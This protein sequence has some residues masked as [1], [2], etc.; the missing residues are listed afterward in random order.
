MSKKYFYTLF[1]SLCI[2]FFSSQDG[3]AQNQNPTVKT[4]ENIEGLYIYPNPIS[5][6]RVYIDTKLNGSKDIALYN[7]LGKKILS[8][9]L[10]G[11]ELILPYNIGSGVYIISIKEKDATATRKIV[12]K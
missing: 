3:R 8:T 12:I 9:T 4:T 1:L 7:I 10:S 2:G 11:R 5:E 6:G